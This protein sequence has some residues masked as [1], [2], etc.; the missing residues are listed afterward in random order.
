LKEAY[1]AEFAAVREYAEKQLILA[2]HGERLL[3]LLD[4]TPITPGDA[5][6]PFD[7]ARE[8]RQILDDAEEDL[9]HWRPTGDEV[10]DLNVQSTTE[11]VVTET[12]P[13]TA[14][15][16]TTTAAS[17]STEPAAVARAE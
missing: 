7:Q 17:A 12:T 5:P 11:P 15:Q 9:R 14:T 4:D 2:Q 6:R 10:D 3:S 13:A 1:A 8:A 16:E